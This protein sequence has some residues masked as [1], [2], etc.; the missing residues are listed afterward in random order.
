MPE[1]IPVVSAQ[2]TNPPSDP[3]APTVVQPSEGG[4]EE[5]MDTSESTTKTPIAESDPCV[6]KMDTSES[7]TKTPIAESDPFVPVPESDSNTPVPESD[8]SNKAI[9][10]LL[11]SK[12]DSSPKTSKESS[13]SKGDDD[14]TKE[15]GTES[16]EDPPKPAVIVGPPEKSGHL[17]ISHTQ[18]FMFNIADGGFTDIHNIWG[19]EKTKGFSPSVWGRRHDYWLLKGVTTYPHYLCCYTCTTVW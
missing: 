17:P 15:N 18:K 7:T 10:L 13:P 6:P 9:K 3:P 19:E 8:S 5:K 14:S 11:T 16:P 2:P 1:L 12:T 4:T